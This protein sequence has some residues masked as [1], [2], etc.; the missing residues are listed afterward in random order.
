M[1]IVHCSCS[2]FQT[3]EEALTQGSVIDRVDDHACVAWP[4]QKECGRLDR[5]GCGRLRKRRKI[6]S[7]RPSGRVL[8]I[9]HKPLRSAQ[10]IHNRVVYAAGRR[11]SNARQLRAD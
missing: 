11:H 5:S 6:L 7:G 10:Y 9:C 4:F 1:D 3:D 2:N 8:H